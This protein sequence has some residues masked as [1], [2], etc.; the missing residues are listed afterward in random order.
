MVLATL[1]VVTGTGGAEAH[2]LKVFATVEGATIRGS[3]YFPGMGVARGVIVKVLAPDGSLIAETA[4]DDQGRFTILALQR[5]D[6]RIVVDTG[7]G[8]RAEFLVPASDLPGSLPL[9]PGDTAVAA[10][11][12]VIDAHPV[13]TPSPTTSELEALVDRVVARHVGLLRE[14]LDA[15]ADRVRFRDILGGLGWIAGITG[16]VCWVAARRRQK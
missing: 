10:P 15:S 12:P 3:A 13:P 7:D 9:A 5:M 8:H 6:H 16:I 2:R 11:L 1:L 4:A 14:Q